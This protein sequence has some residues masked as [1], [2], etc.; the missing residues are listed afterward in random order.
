MRDNLKKI[1]FCVLSV[2]LFSFLTAVGGCVQMQISQN[3]DYYDMRNRHENMSRLAN[4]PAF[5]E[6]CKDT[7]YIIY[8][9]ADGNQYRVSEEDTK[10]LLYILSKATYL[11]SKDFVAWYLAEKTTFQNYENAREYSYTASNNKFLFYKGDDTCITSLAI[12]SCGII[13]ESKIE[14]YLQ[15]ETL[16]GQ[17]SLPDILLD[18]LYDIRSKYLYDVRY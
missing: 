11:P 5:T 4:T 15:S 18:E 8:R 14:E 6:I 7:S 17:I 3:E 9:Y 1:K 12:E 13:E 16:T 10:R 2:F